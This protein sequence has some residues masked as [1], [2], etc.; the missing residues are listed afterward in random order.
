MA[1]A[2]SYLQMMPRLGRNNLILADAEGHLAVF[3]NAYSRSS[4]LEADNGFLIATNHFNS[5]A[6]KDCFVDTEPAP[7]LGNTFHRYQKVKQALTTSLGRIDLDFAKRLMSAHDG[8]LA[9]IC[10]HPIPE[11]HASTISATILLPVQR[12][13]HFC[14]GQPCQTEYRIF[15]LSNSTTQTAPKKYRSAAA[16]CRSG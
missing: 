2:L 12:R 16:Q 8:P 9:S 11:A 5:L 6:L 1:S 3:E 4:V 15:D 7:L 14:H 13:I 10:R